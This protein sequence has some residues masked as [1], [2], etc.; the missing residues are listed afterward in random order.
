MGCQLGWIMEPNAALRNIFVSFV[1]SF[2]PRGDGQ[3][4]G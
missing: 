3:Q 2:D 4:I 1:I